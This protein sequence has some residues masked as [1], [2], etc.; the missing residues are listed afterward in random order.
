MKDFTYSPDTKEWR[1]FFAI[2]NPLL[3]LAVL[4]HIITIQ[5]VILQRQQKSTDAH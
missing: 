2:T 5:Q 4:F 1:V 3:R